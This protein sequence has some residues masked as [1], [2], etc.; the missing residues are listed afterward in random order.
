MARRYW[1]AGNAV[2]RR[3]SLAGG[4]DIPLEI[5]GVARDIKYYSLDESP[6]P[7]V[8][9]SALQGPAAAQILHVRVSG[10]A[11]AF[12]ATLRREIA[13]VDADVVAEQA[14]TFDE[15]RQQPLALRRVMTVMANAFG[16]LTLLLAI[17]G[18][19]GTMS[20]AVGQRTREIG[21]RL[22]F[23][24]RATDVYRL[25]LGDG[26]IPVLM[27][28]ALG[29]AATGLVTRFV[30]SELFGV[31]PGDPLTHLVGVAG[32]VLASAAALSFP[33]HRATQVDP[34]AILRG[35]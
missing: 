21:V 31:T 16:G 12:V 19:Y 30:A 4:P 6:R 8:Y 18:I 2:G 17:V 3:I 23:G 10:D 33:A 15:L 32:V 26:L 11:N 13:A 1:P 25:I 28:V 22:A 35:E 34:V 24:A 27:G 7:Y 5:V 20:N 9:M 29:L 14:M